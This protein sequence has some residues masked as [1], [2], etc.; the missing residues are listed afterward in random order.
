MKNKYVQTEFTLQCQ[1]VEY[2][3]MQYPKVLFKANFAD[4]I[5]LS[6]GQAMKLKRAGSSRAWPDIFIAE[7]KK[8][9]HL[10]P[11]DVVFYSGLFLELKKDGTKLYKKN[12]F[13][14]CQ[15]DHL[16]RQNDVLCGLRKKGYVA[17]F[18]VGFGEAKRVI[19]WYMHL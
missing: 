5:K 1:V 14:E 7:P 12:S 15:T 10:D 4:G 17:K 2:I 9:L 6:I 11:P 18:A 3:K 13:F 19:D 16:A 8:I